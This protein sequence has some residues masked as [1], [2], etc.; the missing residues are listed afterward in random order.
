MG[1]LNGENTHSFLKITKEELE[2][3][4]VKQ[5]SRLEILNDLSKKWGA[6]D[7]VE[8]FD[9]FILTYNTD[10]IITLVHVAMNESFLQG[11]KSHKN[12]KLNDYIDFAEWIQHREIS[13]KIHTHPNKVGKWYCY[14]IGYLNDDELFAEYQKDEEWKLR[15]K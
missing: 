9:D 5:K 4:E 8:S 13:K 7:K 6:K 3:G 12:P 15:K 10:A 1:E 11:I 2:S 14:R